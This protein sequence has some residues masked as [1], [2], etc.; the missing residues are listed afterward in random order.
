MCRYFGKCHINSLLGSN[1]TTK[2]TSWS[3]AWYSVAYDFG[4]KTKTKLYEKIL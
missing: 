4:S 2:A 1:G 3:L